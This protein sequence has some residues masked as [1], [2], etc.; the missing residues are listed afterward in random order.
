MAFGPI[1]SR[2]ARS[3][4]DAGE[5]L[6][7]DPECGV[8]RCVAPVCRVNDFPAVFPQVVAQDHAEAKDE[9]RVPDKRVHGID[10]T[11]SMLCLLTRFG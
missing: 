10:S 4:L 9:K 8:T 1:P 5:H 6:G 2:I 11:W 7:N 3:L